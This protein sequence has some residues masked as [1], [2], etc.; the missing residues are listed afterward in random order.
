MRKLTNFHTVNHLRRVTGLLIILSVALMAPGLMLTRDVPF[1]PAF[2]FLAV[3]MQLN[4]AIGVLLVAALKFMILRPSRTSGMMVLVSGITFIALDLNRFHPL[5]LNAVILLL[6]P[7]ED[8]EDQL[9]GIIIS[10]LLITYLFM[11]LNRINKTYL[12]SFEMLFFWFEQTKRH[13]K[14]LTLLITAFQ[15]LV[16]LSFVLFPSRYRVGAGF[17]VVVALLTEV[18]LIVVGADKQSMV[19]NGLILYVSI[20]LLTLP[21]GSYEVASFKQRAN[22]YAATAIVF[23]IATISFLGLLNKSFSYCTYSGRSESGL[24]L[25]RP[26]KIEFLPPAFKMSLLYLDSNPI[27]DVGYMMGLSYGQTL[28]PDQR[29]IRQ[30]ASPLKNVSFDEQDVVLLLRVGEDIE[31][32]KGIKPYLKSEF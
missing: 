10:I 9:R 21:S 14:E 28:Y 15:G 32:G 18:I 19:W 16:V 5:M 13:I 26:E 29:N 24:I 12:V 7:D 25:V 22:Q 8:T 17:S 2:D 23:L 20:L 27:I 4:I 31:I 11:T 3:S 1:F 30:I 6:L